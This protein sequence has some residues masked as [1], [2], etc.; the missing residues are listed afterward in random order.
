MRVSDYKSHSELKPAMAST[1]SSSNSIATELLSNITKYG[2]KKMVPYI[3]E[4]DAVG[5]ET[6]KSSKLGQLFAVASR[7]HTKMEGR[8]QATCLKSLATSVVMMRWRYVKCC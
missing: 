5:L 8:I 6:F 2:Y 7:A 4:R 1:S 3:N